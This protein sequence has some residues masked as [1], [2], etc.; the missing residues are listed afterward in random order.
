MGVRLAGYIRVSTEGQVDAY[1]KDVQRDSIRRWALLNGHEVT[2]WYEEDGVSGTKDSGDRPELS[3]LVREAE[4]L[5]FNGVI[6]FDATRIARR[7]VVQETLLALM[8]GAGLKVFTTTAGELSADEDDPTKILIRQIL[9]IIAEFDHRT[10]VKKLHAARTIKA[11]QGGYVGGTPKFGLRV[12]GAGK[13]AQFEEDD[14]ESSVIETIV[15]LHGCGFSLRQIADHLNRGN[16]PT[17]RGKTWLAPQVQRIIQRSN[18]E[19]P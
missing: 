14:V 9:G 11:S 6:V 7:V 15:R 1:G 17:K 4:T 18:N 8:W 5:E 12:V 2:T 13:A 3:A 19:Q 16:I 10:T